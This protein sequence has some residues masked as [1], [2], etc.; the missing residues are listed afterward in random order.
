[1][2][3]NLTVENEPKLGR[4]HYCF[5][6]GP[7]FIN[8]KLYFVNKFEESMAETLSDSMTV[9]QFLEEQFQLI[10]KVHQIIAINNTT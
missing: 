4:L 7:L 9:E 1:M 5:F 3:Y 8:I 10:L 6:Q 2:T